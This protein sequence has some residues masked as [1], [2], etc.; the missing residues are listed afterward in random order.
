MSMKKLFPAYRGTIIVDSSAFFFLFC[1][2]PE[3][4]KNMEFQ[5]FK[6][7]NGIDGGK[8]RIRHYLGALDFLAQQGYHIVVPEM[9]AAEV[10]SVLACGTSLFDHADIEHAERPKLHDSQLVNLIVRGIKGAPNMTLV[11]MHD[12]DDEDSRQ[13]Q[14]AIKALHAIAKMPPRDEITKE[15]MRVWREGA[16]KDLGEKAIMRYIKDQ[17]LEGRDNVFVLSNDVDA[18]GK[19]MTQLN[20]P[21][22][23]CNGFLQG[24]LENKLGVAMGLKEDV[25]YKSVLDACYRNM[26]KI[27]GTKKYIMGYADYMPIEELPG[28]KPSHFKSAMKKLARDIGVKTWVDWAVR[29]YPTSPEAGRS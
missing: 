26:E 23:N 22:V 12:A 16:P 2:V 13:V 14:S 25:R 17:H 7:R 11:E 6:R 9:V 29:P 24:L 1:K 5:Q 21:V 20:V 15:A 28:F 10:A 19:I 27:T 8:T 3:D 18:M 4:Q